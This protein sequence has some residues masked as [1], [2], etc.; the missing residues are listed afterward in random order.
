MK[1]IISLFLLVL[2]F[3]SMAAQEN[4]ELSTLRIGPF[5]IFMEKSEAE[6]IA[7][8]KLKISDGEQKNVVKYNGETINIE[9]FQGYGGEAKP[10]AVTI[11]GM[12]TTS[13]K[14][15]TKSGMGVG[16]TRDELINAYKNYPTFSVRPDMDNNGKRIKDAGYFNIED[17]DAG[18]Q[19][20]FKFVNNIVTEI[21]VYI[22]EGC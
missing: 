6:K 11:A 9:V 14:F 16:S 21:T 7:G 20:T 4:F 17:Y 10:D 18:T 13:K 2:T 19:L 1:K 15:K 3:G 8:A 5:K 22:N 12:T